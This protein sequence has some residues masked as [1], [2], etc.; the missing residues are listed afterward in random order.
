MNPARSF[1]KVFVVA[2]TFLVLAACATPL[3]AP[4][5]ADAARSKLTQLQ[6]DPQLASRAP[7]E[8]KEAGVAV[9]AA[10]VPR[11]DDQHAR[12]LVLL[13]D[14]KVE[15]ARARA[16]SRLYEDDRRALSEKSERM[17][18]DFRTQEADRART[19]ATAARADAAMARSDANEARRLSEAASD[20]AR[21]ETDELQRQIAELNA[22]ETD[23]GLVVTLGDLLFETGRSE[24]KGGAAANLDKLAVFLNEYEDRSVLIEGH[25]DDVGSDEANYNLSERRA[26]SVQSYLV[27]QG[28]RTHRLSTS[29]LGEGSP[30]ATNQTATGRQQ[31]RRVEVIISNATTA[32]R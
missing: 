32:A 2:A 3:T 20:A 10:E 15:I 1:A 25:T 5:G 19:D 13:A 21:L 22:R 29:G 23:R 17:R 4:A 8:L 9:K 28:I 12:H 11:E 7:V 24:L 18:L 26:N 31:N 6:S 27:S 14:S 16:Q 30:I